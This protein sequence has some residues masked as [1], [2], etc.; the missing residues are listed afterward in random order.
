MADPAHWDEIYA[1]KEA[2][3]LSWTEPEPTVSLAL[4]DRFADASLPLVDVGGGRSE[5]VDHLLLRGW[6]ALTVL[7]LSAAALALVRDRLGGRPEVELV[8]GDVTDFVPARPLG[9]WHDRA[10]LHFLV[11]EA[12]QLAYARRAAAALLSDGIAVI[13][14]FAPDGPER[15]SGLE[16]VRRSPE[17]VAELLGPAFELVAAERHEHHTPWGAAQAFSWAVLRRRPA[18]AS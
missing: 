3:E 14:C 18:E 7:D 15:C 4:L 2:E 12:D 10:V 16:V 11:D 1:A 13:G 5:L 9:T 8:V 17:E 6:T